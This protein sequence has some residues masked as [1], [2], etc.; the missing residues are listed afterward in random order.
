MV[1]DKGRSWW[2]C[3]VLALACG[4][5]PSTAD[6]A[7]DGDGSSTSTTG[8]SATM[9]VPATTEESGSADGSSSSGDD[10]GSASEDEADSTAGPII[11]DVGSKPDAPPG[12]PP[13][14][15]GETNGAEALGVIW[16]SNS[17]QGT[18][19]KIDTE[20]LAELGRYSTRPDGN[21]NPSRTSVN[22]NGDV[23]VANR[24]GGVV[25]IHGDLEECPD[26]TNT[27]GGAADVLPW[28]D[29]C[30]GW[31]TAMAYASQRPVA[32]TAGTW[33]DRACR[34]VDMDVWT[35]GANAMIDT[36]FLDG[37]TG[38]IEQTIAVPGVPANFFGIYGGAVDSMDH[39]WGSQLSTGFLVRV[40]R[41]DFTVESWPM[42]ETGY[43]MTVDRN[44]RVWT[45]AGSPARFDYATETW[46]SFVAGGF[47][48]CAPGLDGTLWLAN[49]PIVQID[50]ESLAVVQT[51][52]V[53]NYVH[54]IS[55]DFEGRVFG[56]TPG[57]SAYR[58]DPAT[59]TVDE[60]AGFVNAYTYSDMT[61]TA[62]AIVSGQL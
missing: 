44:D 15:G 24:S 48:G 62:L 29:G 37:D 30:I 36:I 11:F 1:I 12:D 21:G 56:V 2:W 28:Q 51:F 18:V 3:G 39:F 14:P 26:S 4:P 19:S 5:G 22:R 42:P 8:A 52:D 38:A 17:T 7:G 10:S 32:W 27:S 23:V 41:D 35:A 61:G 43:G 45:C 57:A 33:D 55:M 53:P 47:G 20:S 58:L 6:G 31:Y 60:V 59:G 16:I 25:M 50:V 54:G 46:E 40:D 13:C 49:D 9:D 34:Y